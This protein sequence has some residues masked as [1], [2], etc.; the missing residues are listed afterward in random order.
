V[1]ARRSQ[2]PAYVGCSITWG[3]DGIGASV[4]E[5]LQGFRAIVTEIM[6]ILDG[7]SIR[8]EAEGKGD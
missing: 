1:L 8:D 3:G 6:K 5:E 4:E 2:K 7:Q